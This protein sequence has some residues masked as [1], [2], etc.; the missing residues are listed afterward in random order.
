MCAW[1]FAVVLLVFTIV[2]SIFAV[3]PVLLIRRD[4]RNALATER[5]SWGIGRAASDEL[6]IGPLE[7][8]QEPAARGRA[9]S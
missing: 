7:P 9:S 3:Y 2:L 4:E 5:S 8:L 1:S 6:R